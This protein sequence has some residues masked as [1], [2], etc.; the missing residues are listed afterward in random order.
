MGRVSNAGEKQKLRRVD[1]PR[2]QDDLA[3]SWVSA[4]RFVRLSLDSDGSCSVENDPS[5][6]G[7]AQYGQVGPVAR[8]M[9]IGCCRAATAA[10][11]RKALCDVEAF[12]LGAVLI[13]CP[14]VPCFCAGF[15]EGLIEGMRRLTTFD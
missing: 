13:L 7:F 6:Q 2:G 3:G 1:R 14:F 4:Y 9:Q 8:R 5:C 11:A 15:Q 12:V 10:F